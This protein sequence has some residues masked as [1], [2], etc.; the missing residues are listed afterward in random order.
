MAT[1]RKRR[2]Q[3]ISILSVTVVLL[4]AAAACLW[5]RQSNAKPTTGE[6]VKMIIA[7]AHGFIS[8]L[9]YIA[10]YEGYFK[11]EGLDVSF[12]CHTSGRDAMKQTLAGEAMLATVADTPIVHSVLAGER[13]Y[14]IATIATTKRALAILGRK[15]RGIAAAADLVNKKIGVTAGTN[16]EFFLD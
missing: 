7:E 1:P 12:Q 2:I 11:A 10:K 3:V 5:Q 6:P 14:A 16:G 8:A 13:V 4:V 9:V 15:D